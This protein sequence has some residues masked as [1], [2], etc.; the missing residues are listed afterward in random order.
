METY[1]NN[2]DS[3]EVIRQERISELRD[4]GLI[5]SELTKRLLKIIETEKKPSIVA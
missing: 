1:T 2:L 4:N 3:R 5:W